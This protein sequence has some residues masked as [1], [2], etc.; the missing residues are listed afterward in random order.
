MKFQHKVKLFIALIIF[1]LIILLRFTGQNWLTFETFKENREYLLVLV[2]KNYL[3]VA[4]SFI[5][6]YAMVVIST[7]PLAALMTIV[8]GFLFGSILGTIFSTIGG[9]IGS[10]VSFLMFRYLIGWIVQEKYASK[11]IKFNENV[12]VYGAGYVFLIH[13]ATVIPFSIINILAS[14]TKI[15]LKKFIIGTFFGIIPGTLV[16]SYA[17]K[18]LGQIN[19][20]NEIFSKKIILALSLLIL[21]SIISYLVARLCKE[22]K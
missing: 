17:G 16:Y 2:D 10:I 4:L 19:S 8:G 18:Q 12:E 7:L 11:L 1:C 14:L 5:C 3:L 13:V 20:F 6:L 21:L 15:P 22:R 9:I